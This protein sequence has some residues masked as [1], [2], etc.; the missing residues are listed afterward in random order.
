MIY[1]TK[2][3]ISLILKG[4]YEEVTNKRA[5]VLLNIFENLIFKREVVI[6]FY[7]I[8][9]TFSSNSQAFVIVSFSFFYIY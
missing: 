8:K 7:A 3:R 2:R 1:F 6:N 4:I 9:I 5:L